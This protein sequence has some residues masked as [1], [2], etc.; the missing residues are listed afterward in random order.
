MAWTESD[1]QAIDNIYQKFQQAKAQQN[2]AFNLQEMGLYRSI[3]GKLQALQKNQSDDLESLWG[4]LTEILARCWLANVSGYFTNVILTRIKDNPDLTRNQ[5]SIEALVKFKQQN[6]DSELRNKLAISLNIPSADNLDRIANI[7]LDVVNG[8]MAIILRHEDDFPELRKLL[9][10][11]ENVRNIP[12]VIAEKEDIYGVF[13]DEKGRFADKASDCADDGK[14]YD[15]HFLYPEWEPRGDQEEPPGRDSLKMW[16]SLHAKNRS[17]RCSA[18]GQIY[19]SDQQ[20][21]ADPKSLP[22]LPEVRENNRHI[23]CCLFSFCHHGRQN[24]EPTQQKQPTLFVS[25]D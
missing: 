9:Q 4:N 6:V 2:A 14:E 24:G 23:W 20:V 22:N 15:K 12:G 10:E 18:G 5:R 3:G 11:Q 17:A 19:P 1:R 25:N 8:I 21:I 16:R 7:L 13:E